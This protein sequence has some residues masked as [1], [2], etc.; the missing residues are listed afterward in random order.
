MRLAAVAEALAEALAEADPGNARAYRDNA[1]AYTAELKELDA[2]FR[3][4]LASCSSRLLVVSHAAFAYLAD[5]YG[6]RQEAIAGISPETEPDPAR[7]AELD[8]LVRRE[9]V[10]TI[11]TETLASPDVA[12]TLAAEA[13]VTTA[14]LNPLEGLTQAQLEAGEDYGSLM[15][16]NLRTLRSALGCA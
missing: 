16:E 7:L 11:F 2:G 14:V 13:G 12:E 5:A 3:D 15:R 6:L 1:A 8:E 9:G 10:T 4:G